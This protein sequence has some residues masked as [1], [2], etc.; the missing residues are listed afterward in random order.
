[1][2]VP[3]EVEVDSFIGKHHS[4]IYDLTDPSQLKLPPNYVV[5]IL[6]ASRGIGEH[7]AYAYAAAGASGIILASRPSSQ[8]SLSAV[9]HKARSLNAHATIKTAACN[10]TSSS[11]VADLANMIEA[12]F[13]R[14]D[15]VVVNAGFAGPITLHVDEGD[16]AHFKTCTDVNYLG[17]YQ[18][19]HWLLPLL[20]HTKGGGKTFIVVSALAA[21][22]TRGPIANVGY[23]VS[24]VAQMRLVEMIAEQ[25]GKDGVLAV[26]VHPG[27]VKTKMA[28]VAPE[29]FVPHLI[30]SP[31][32]CGGFCVWLC[33]NKEQ[34]QW[35]TGRFVCATWDIEE[36]LSRERDV[37]EQDLLK[38]KMA[39]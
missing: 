5:C 25:Y 18:A 11:S 21:L 8:D 17:P 16:P 31:A 32:L 12:E 37:V 7:I 39:I 28:E 26:A 9:E 33:A 24:K 15:T 13:Q 3:N 38:L 19:A 29:E 30:D 34:W 6:G 2:G 14:L 20:R 10:L 23:C 4:A 27:A 1:M 22:I 35:M 36:L